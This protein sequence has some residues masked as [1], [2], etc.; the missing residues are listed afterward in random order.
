MLK[1]FM[2]GELMKLNLNV[3]LIEFDPDILDVVVS[4]FGVAGKYAMIFGI[5]YFVVRMVARA[6]TGKERFL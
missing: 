5:M 6:A 3:E 1:I 4:F 2:K